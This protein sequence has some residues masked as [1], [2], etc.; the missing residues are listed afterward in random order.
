MGGSG[1]HNIQASSYSAHSLQSS[2][3]TSKTLLREVI[4]KVKYIVL[5]QMGEA[6]SDARSGLFLHFGKKLK[7]KTRGFFLQKLKVCSPAQQVSW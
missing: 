5:T 7:G 2:E 1:F 3:V 4:M 6:P